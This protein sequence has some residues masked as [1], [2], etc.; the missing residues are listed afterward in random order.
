MLSFERL[1]L[2]IQH[3]ILARAFDC[4]ENIGWAH[5]FIGRHVC[6]PWSKMIQ[7][8]FC[9]RKK[10][11]PLNNPLKIGDY[12]FLPQFF[13]FKYELDKII[14]IDLLRKNGLKLKRS[15]ETVETVAIV[16]ADT[17]AVARGPQF[18]RQEAIIGN[19]TKK[20]DC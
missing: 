18:K 14:Y 17:M 12:F 13:N 19:K 16:I 2:E 7:C 10:I 1:P 3:L 15:N 6:L 4:R 5:S 9:H 8:D 20:E 11:I